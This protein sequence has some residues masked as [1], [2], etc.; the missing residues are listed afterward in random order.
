M[1]SGDGYGREVFLFGERGHRVNGG[2]WSGGGFNDGEGVGEGRWRRNRS[3][4]HSG[5]NGWDRGSRNEVRVVRARHNILVIVVERMRVR[6][7]RW[8]GV[9]F[10]SCSKWTS[11]F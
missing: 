10:Y 4:R 8:W 1:D 6:E 11:H 2:S 3:G 7:K 9:A 5:S